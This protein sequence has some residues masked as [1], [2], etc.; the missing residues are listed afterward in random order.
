LVPL[1]PLLH[2]Q[3][4]NSPATQIFLVVPPELLPL[5]DVHPCNATVTPNAIRAERSRGF[6]M[7][8]SPLEKEKDEKGN[9]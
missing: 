5:L 3:T 9:K 4:E 8:S 7:T 2:T 1:S 6:F